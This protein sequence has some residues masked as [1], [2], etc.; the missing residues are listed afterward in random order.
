MFEGKIATYLWQIITFLVGIIITLVGWIIKKH[1]TK[2]EDNADLIASLETMPGQVERLFAVML[3]L[4]DD[5]T[6]MLETSVRQEEVNRLWKEIDKL[7]KELSEMR[8]DR[9][10]V[11]ESREC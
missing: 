2:T 6:R 7:D 4:Q 10:D 9:C 8:K 11:P 1:I 3:K 5:Y